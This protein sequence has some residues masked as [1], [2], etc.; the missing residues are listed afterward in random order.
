M[1]KWEW[2]CNMFN[3][4]LLCNLNLNYWLRIS[5]QLVFMQLLLPLFH[6]LFIIFMTV[7]KIMD[8][9]IYSFLFKQFIRLLNSLL[10]QWVS[11]WWLCLRDYLFLW[12]LLWLIQLVKWRN[13]IIWWDIY[14]PVRRWE[15]WI[16]FV[17]IKQVLWLKI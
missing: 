1:G 6:F 10:L 2:G 7:Q 12:L 8:F 3:N 4:K 5:D 13:K 16:I 9:S 11:L 14:M 17:L 15:M